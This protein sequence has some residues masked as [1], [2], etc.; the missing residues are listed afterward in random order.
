MECISHAARRLVLIVPTLLGASG[1][2]FVLTML[3][4]GDPA[5]VRLGNFATAEQLQSLRQ[6]MGLTRPPLERYGRYCLEHPVCPH[7]CAPGTQRDVCRKGQR[8]CR[9]GARARQFSDASGVAALAPSFPLPTH[10]PVHH[11]Y[12]L[13]H[14]EHRWLGLFRRGPAAAHARMGRDDQRRESCVWTVVDVV[15]PWSGP[16]PHDSRLYC[17]RRWP[18]CP[19]R[20]VVEQRPE[21]GIG[22]INYA[23]DMPLAEV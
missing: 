18:E 20:T 12:L 9:G 2:M 16:H 10:S 23:L 8:I 22:A 14:S 4:P 15:F 6:E 21:P 3:I 1:L 7:V 11:E 5:L 17:G 13:G 19:Y